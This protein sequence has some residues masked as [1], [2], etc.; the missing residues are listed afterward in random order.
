MLFAE[1][2]R[3]FILAYV[4]TLSQSSEPGKSKRHAE[5]TRPNTTSLYRKKLKE[6]QK[7]KAT[8]NPNLFVESRER[9]LVTP[10]W[11]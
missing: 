8:D 10:S 6:R 4:S 1:M 7:T 9:P 5:T 11:R 3:R 2:G